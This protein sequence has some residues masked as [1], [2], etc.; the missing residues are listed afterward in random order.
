MAWLFLDTSALAR[1]YLR[2][3]PDAGHVAALCRPRSGHTLVISRLT[4]A[5]IASALARARRAGRIDEVATRRR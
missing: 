1:R 2:A 4:S 3:E 5:E